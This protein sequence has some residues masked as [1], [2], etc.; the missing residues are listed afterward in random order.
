MAWYTRGFAPYVPARAR[1]AQARREARALAKQGEALDPVQIEGRAIARTFWG[2]AWCR[3]IET[4]SDYSNRLPRGRTYARNGSVLDLKLEPGR[5]R[6]RVMGSTLYRVK[7]DVAPLDPRRWKA[8]VG[9]CAGEIDSVVELLS[10]TLSD[11]VMTRLCHPDSGLFPAAQQLTMSCSC[12]DYAG[13]CKHLAAV[14]YGIGARLDRQPELLF[15]LRG[16]DK[17]DLVS[18]TTG[19]ALTSKQG[20]ADELRGDRLADIFGIELDGEAAP[21][22]VAAPPVKPAVARRRKAAASPL[23]PGDEGG[24]PATEQRRR[25]ARSPAPKARPG[26]EGVSQGRTPGAERLAGPRAKKPARRREVR[27]QVEEL[28]DAIEALAK[29]RARDFAALDR[30]LAR[31]RR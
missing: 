22:A 29:A 21:E 28:A 4:Y 16:V 25:A 17:L 30:A 19:A 26:G 18:A 15:E 14:L 6:A 12:P 24:A 7:V 1:Q 5:V 9:G 3:H 11:G 13:L 31:R 20:G 8:L 27:S 10:G 23:T 2:Q